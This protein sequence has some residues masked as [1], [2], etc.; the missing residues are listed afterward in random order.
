MDGIPFAH[1]RPGLP[2]REPSR[3]KVVPTQDEAAE[4]CASRDQAEPVDQAVGRVPLLHNQQ[5]CMNS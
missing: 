5:R 3:T 1:W 4:C 2:L